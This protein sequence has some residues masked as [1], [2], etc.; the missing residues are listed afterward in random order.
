MNSD[1]LTTSKGEGLWAGPP[2]KASGGGLDVGVPSSGSKNAPVP[3]SIGGGEAEMAGASG[4]PFVTPTQVI[5]GELQRPSVVPLI[6]VENGRLTRRSQVDNVIPS[7]LAQDLLLAQMSGVG[8]QQIASGAGTA[9]NPY[10]FTD[11]DPWGASQSASIDAAAAN[12]DITGVVFC[13]DAII[14]R[15]LETAAPGQMVD[16]TLN[17][18]LNDG[19][20]RTQYARVTVELG[21]MSE[22]T[23]VFLVP[24][25]FIQGEAVPFL[26]SDVMSDLG[27][28]GF[29]LTFSQLADTSVRVI[30]GAL[31]DSF[32]TRMAA[33]LG[34]K[35]P[36]FQ[37]IV[38]MPVTQASVTRRLPGLGRSSQIDVVEAA[39]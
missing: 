6:T 27:T 20:G 23:R 25:R 11:I 17:S 10:V 24:H 8:V 31:Q 30:A 26:A 35:S 36:R 13:I 38:R 28:P 12:L 37:G 21:R 34:V 1:A 39:S 15:P 7:E 3:V 5:M 19:G 18:R 33:L 16:L 22:E 14:T 4:G 29:T 9:G 32:T 2:S